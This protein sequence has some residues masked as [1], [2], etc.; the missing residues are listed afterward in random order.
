[1]NSV[2]PVCEPFDAP[3]NGS[4][5]DDDDAESFLD[6]GSVTIICDSKFRREGDETFI[7]TAVENGTSA[8][9]SPNPSLTT[10]GKFK[11]LPVFIILVI[12]HYRDI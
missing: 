1:M 8:A 5:I 10:C 2:P 3:H 9:W 7:C 6:G 12:L 4:V 11:S